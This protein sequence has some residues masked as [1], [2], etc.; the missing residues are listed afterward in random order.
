MQFTFFS[1]IMSLLWFN[2][3]II[4]INSFRKNDNFIISFTTFPLIFF[5]VLSAFRLIF[6]FEVPGS[7]IIESKTIFPKI[8]DFFRIPLNLKGFSINI[9]QIIIVIWSTVA[10]VLLISSIIKYRRFKSSLYEL[11]KTRNRENERVFNK[12]L[13]KYQMSE[14]IKMI[15]HDN[16]SSPFIL[17]LL[18]GKIYIPNIS[19]SQEE[20]EYII[21]HEIN[22]FKRKD[23]LKKILIQSIKN[24]FWWNPFS[25][26]FANNF[27][28]ILEIQCDLKTTSSFTDDKKIRYL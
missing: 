22:H 23:S 13:S 6:N 21:L 7:I 10:I 8:Y 28:H 3:Y 20:L 11:D 16:I 5:L 24:I 4:I 26:L 15:Q 9:I 12:I 1:F 18:N 25:H 27:D 17:G 2:L 14:K 19:F